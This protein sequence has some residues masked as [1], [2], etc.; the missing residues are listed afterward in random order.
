[1]S[2]KRIIFIML[3]LLLA[4]TACKNKTPQA[5]KRFGLG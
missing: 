3:T 1:M 2:L 5:D 4:L